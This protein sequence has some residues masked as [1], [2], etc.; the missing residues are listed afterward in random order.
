MSL[1]QGD[2]AMLDRHF[3]HMNKMLEGI[4]HA[5]EGF[6]EVIRDACADYELSKHEPGCKC[7]SH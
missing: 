7:G 5:L 3:E 2:H 4:L 1:D 6:T